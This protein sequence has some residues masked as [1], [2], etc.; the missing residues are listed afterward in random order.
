VLSA[1]THGF[2][3]L[4]LDP[5]QFVGI[6]LALVGAVFLSVGAQLQHRGV[7]KVDSAT[8]GDAGAGGLNLGQLRL[9][10][11]RPSWVTGTLMLGAAIVLQLTSLAFAP[12]IVVQPLGAFALV[13]TSVV[14]SRVTGGRL[15]RLSLLAICLCIAGVGAFVLIAAFQARELPVDERELVQILVILCVVLVFFALG[16]AAFRHRMRA[17]VYV[18]GAG[19]L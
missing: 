19:V 10:L 13:V 1:A 18:V 11:Q 8:V 15:N 2:D 6:P 17:I 12:L 4:A 7:T 14:N 5:K 9:L 3:P 16:F